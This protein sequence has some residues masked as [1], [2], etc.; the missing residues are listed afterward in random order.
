MKSKK[1]TLSKVLKNYELYLF[2]LPA[3][4]YF[5]IF[6][7]VPMYGITIAFKN[8]K[9]SLGIIGS[10]WIGFHHFERFFKSY[11]F[12][13]LIVNTL[14]LSVYRLAVGFV[15]PIIFALLLNQI[16]SKRFKKT[17]QMAT[18]A[19]HFISMVVLVGMLNIFI[20]PYTGFINQIVKATG[21]EPILFAADPK[22][23]STL[24]VFSGVW[25][26]MGWE[27]I[28]YI[29][30]LAGIS[31]ELYEAASIDGAGKFKKI[32][33]IDIPGIL[34]TIIV[35]LILNTGK[36]MNIGFEKAYLMQNPV[37]L[38]ASEIIATYV[39]KV[40]LLNFQFSFSTAVDLFNT[41]INFILLFA[42]NIV[43]KRT[44]DIYL[45]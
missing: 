29:A 9:P 41:V 42:V 33:H 18:Y 44:T 2:L 35:L 32:L 31:P 6:H 14:S 13:E 1:H 22:W 45:W 37:N 25:Q 8:F 20:S 26:N 12:K 30:A 5:V 7:Y 19:P 27:A 28:I 39:Y 10:P 15:V 24:Y 40:G 16:H 17:V 43:S 34:P 38:E 23:F 3:I 36:I 4:I 21:R 11:Y